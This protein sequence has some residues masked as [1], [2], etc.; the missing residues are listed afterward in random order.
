[1]VKWLVTVELGRKS[2]FFVLAVFDLSLFL[3]SLVLIALD[4]SQIQ[5]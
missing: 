5:T 2:T 3:I 4:A 1:M